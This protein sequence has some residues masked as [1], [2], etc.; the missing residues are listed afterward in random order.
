MIAQNHKRPML[1]IITQVAVMSAGECVVIVLGPDPLDLVFRVAEIGN[2][3]NGMACVY[4]VGAVLPAPFC[5]DDH[6]QPV[7][8]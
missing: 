4:A 7:A 2:V 5:V 1:H 3:V 6:G 8:R